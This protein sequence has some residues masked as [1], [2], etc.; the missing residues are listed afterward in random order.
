[1]AGESR[2]VPQ[3]TVILSAM[4]RA[5]LVPGALHTSG[6]TDLQKKKFERL[7]FDVEAGK[8]YYVLWSIGSKMK[9][10]DT[11]TGAKEIG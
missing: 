1:M 10:V 5:C 9:V 7:R 3:G 11:A 2:E 6:I 8:T 4:P